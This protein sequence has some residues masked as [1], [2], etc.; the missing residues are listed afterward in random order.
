M[1]RGKAKYREIPTVRGIGFVVASLRMIV[2]HLARGCIRRPKELSSPR[3]IAP[4][5]RFVA[6]GRGG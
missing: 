6:S 4:A 1:F 2:A 3:P 5:Q